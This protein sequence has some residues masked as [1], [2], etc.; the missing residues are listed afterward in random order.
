MKDWNNHLGKPKE[1]EVDGEK[2]LLSPLGFEDAAELL[3]LSRLFGRDVEK[4]KNAMTKDVIISL[5]TLIAK[6]LKLSYPDAEIET[7]KKWALKY[8]S[9]LW[10][11]LFN[12][13]WGDTGDNKIES[14]LEDIRA[15][16][17]ADK[18]Q[19]IEGQEQK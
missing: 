3:S 4:N 1:I 14:K 5:S 17:N 9:D 7:L 13:Q 8:F 11:E 18:I 6:S 12:I 16:M 2:I 19:G 10:V 15:R